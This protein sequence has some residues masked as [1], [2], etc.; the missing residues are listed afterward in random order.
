M[1]EKG[2]FSEALVRECGAEEQE[3]LEAIASLLADPNP[4]TAVC[5]GNDM[6]ALNAIKALH[7]KGLRVPQDFSVVGFDDI[8]AA[9]FS[10]PALTT[11]HT[12]L[13]ECGYES[14]RLLRQLLTG[15]ETGPVTKCLSHELIVRDSCAQFRHRSSVATGASS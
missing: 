13:Y 15:K 6:R 11:V 4:P 2:M 12:P 9:A 7:A 14:V 10:V 3:V 5:T 8:P 1:Q